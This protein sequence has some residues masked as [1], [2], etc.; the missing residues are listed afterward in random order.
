MKKVSIILPTYNSE[1]TIQKCV[2]SIL[3][4]SY[5]NFELICVDDGSKDNTTS[6]LSNFQLKDN[7][8]LFFPQK[9]NSI[10]QKL[11]DTL[12]GIQLGKIEAPEGWIKVISE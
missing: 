11:Y 1:R 2:N 9:E 12:T 10:S 4:Q 6:M 7:R 5:T 3:S 8:I